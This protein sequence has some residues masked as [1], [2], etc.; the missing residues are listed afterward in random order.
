[1]EKSNIRTKT[2]ESDLDYE[3]DF[4][5]RS[6]NPVVAIVGGTVAS[7]MGDLDIK[8]TKSEQFNHKGQNPLHQVFI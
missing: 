7:Q 2:D 6:I 4:Y 1:M 5:F 8:R 3:K